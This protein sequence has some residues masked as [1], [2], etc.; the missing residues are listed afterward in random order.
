MTLYLLLCLGW[1]LALVGW[2][3]IAI[4]AYVIRTLW[5]RY[6]AE[7]EAITEMSVALDKALSV[8]QGQSYTQARDIN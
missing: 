8:A 6:Q 4:G 3:L 5:Q 1:T 2:T 7:Q